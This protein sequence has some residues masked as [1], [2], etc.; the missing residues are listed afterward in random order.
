M[1]LHHLELFFYVARHEGIT[2]ALR[3]IPYGIQ[4]P[5]V[6]SQLIQLEKD[7]GI[8]LFVR[9]P[10]ALTTAGRE[11][12]E[13]LAPFFS[14]IPEIP[15]QL[16]GE[17]APRLCV[18]A[19]GTVFRTHLPAIF[20]E[21]RKRHC[22]LRLTLREARPEHME[23]LLRRQEVE[24]A[25]TLRQPEAP[26]PFHFEEL[27]TLP[28]VLWAP[29]KS[30]FRVADALKRSGEPQETLICLPAHERVCR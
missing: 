29:K 9:R 4:Q 8:Q 16:R 11:L 2:P 7:I 26:G 18:A 20:S 12:Y 5:A 19:S 13:F 27:I 15:R 6:S 10:F 24:L 21:L 14:A 28:L 23:E 1:N 17:L 30:A 3:H 22:G 25:L